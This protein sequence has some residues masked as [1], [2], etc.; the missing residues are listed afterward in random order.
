[1]RNEPRVHLP[2]AVELD[3]DF[4]SRLEGRKV[5][6]DHRPAHPAILRMENHAHAR[7]SHSFLDMAARAFR[8]A[9]IDNENA[10]N[11]RTDPGQHTFDVPA[12]AVAGNDNGDFQAAVRLMRRNSSV[13]APKR[14]KVL[15]RR[16]S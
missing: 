14:S 2:V 13:L 10:V 5:S 1:M 11:F 3:H 8:A 16:Y 7:I 12:D 9:I 6:G 4:G 15:Q